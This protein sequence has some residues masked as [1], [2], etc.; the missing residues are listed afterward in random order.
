MI[1]RPGKFID[2][3]KS[4]GPEASSCGYPDASDSDMPSAP[5]WGVPPAVDL[6]PVSAGLFVSFGQGP[7]SA[8]QP[9][10]GPRSTRQLHSRMCWTIRRR[11]HVAFC[12]SQGL[13]FSADLE[14]QC[15]THIVAQFL[16]DGRWP[17]H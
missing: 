17:E 8:N 1:L 16:S 4:G 12:F 7:N 10:A 5:L 9:H 3:R 14:P 6:G 11:D 13:L 2:A 15:K